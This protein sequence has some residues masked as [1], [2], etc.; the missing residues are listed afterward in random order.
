M[1][2]LWATN[3][4]M[5]HPILAAGSLASSLFYDVV[6]FQAEEENI[7]QLR[8][9]NDQRTL[10][11]VHSRFDLVLRKRRSKHFASQQ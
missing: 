11:R 4:I 2:E 3:Q 8:N 10:L 7:G 1:K 5:V 6:L 9:L